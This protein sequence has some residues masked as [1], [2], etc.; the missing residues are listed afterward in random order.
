MASGNR[1]KGVA[2]KTE[3]SSNANTCKKKNTETAELL[4]KGPDE[5]AL[6]GSRD[7]AMA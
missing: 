6:T 7:C 3:N 5:G 1:V 2:G 4:R